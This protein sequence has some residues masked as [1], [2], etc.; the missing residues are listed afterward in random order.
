M[1]RHSRTSQFWPSH[2]DRG[3]SPELPAP[4]LSRCYRSYLFMKGT[5][6]WEILHFTHLVSLGALI[7]RSASTNRLE[8]SDLTYVLPE[9]PPTIYTAY[10]I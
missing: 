3:E 1:L 6:H 9:R 10:H 5:M 7:S 8:S 2:D 4:P